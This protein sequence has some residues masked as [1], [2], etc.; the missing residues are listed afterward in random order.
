[1]EAS[2]HIIQDLTTI[3]V[4]ASIVSILFS[5]LRWPSILGYILSGLIVGPYTTSNLVIRDEASIHSI[6]ELGVI[7]LMFCIGL[8][9]DLKKL[10]QTLFPSFLA[11]FLQAIMAFFTGAMVAHCLG[12][13][14]ILGTF[15]GA[16]FAI[17]SSM[18]AVPILKHKNALKQP[19]AQ[20]TIGV[21]VLEDIFA[22]ILLVVLSN[23]RNGHF[24][25]AECI[26]LLFWITVFISSM[27]IFGRLAAQRFIKLLH[28]IANEEIAHICVVGLIL[29]LSALSSRYSNA[30][31]AFLAGAIFSST[32]INHKLETMIA[33]IRDVFTAVF[34]V[35]IGMLIDPKIIGHNIGLI[36]ILSIVVFF[37]QLISAGLGFFLSGQKGVVAFRAALPKSQ[38]GEFSFVIAALAQSLGVDN[39]YLMAITVGIALFTIIFVNL[40]SAKEEAVIDRFSRLIPK[41]LKSWGELYQNILAS[42]QTHISGNRLWNIV[43]KPILKIA[44]HFFLINAIV[45]CNAL[46][47]EFLIDHPIPRTEGYTIWLQRALSLLSLCIAL[48]FMTSLIR[49]LHLI[50]ISI[51]KHTLKG[52]F[53]KLNQHAALY[54]IFQLFIT[55]IATVFFTWLF[56][57]SSAQYLPSY[58]PILLLA[59][60]G[61]I[62]GFAFWRKLRSMNSQFEVMF[63]ES[64][65]SAL[66]SE[67]EKRN[68][69]LIKMASKKHPW[70]MQTKQIIVPKNSHLIGQTLSGSGLRQKTHTTLLGIGRNGYFS[71]NIQ[72]TSLFYPGDHLLLL[73]NESQLQAAEK[74]VSII[75]SHATLNEAEL[76]FDQIVITEQHPLLN[77]TLESAAIRKNYNLNVIGIQRKDRRMDSLQPEDII[78]AGDCLLVV[79]H[80]SAI[81][82]L[83]QLGLS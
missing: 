17:S 51:C 6:S 71:E 57:I 66:E 2:H 83:Q 10:Q 49:N 43:K 23:A 30:L 69:A 53:A 16:I 5:I 39:G 31:G 64:F 19:F 60:V 35:S 75:Q 74:F 8:E 24:N 26:N 40:L 79:G 14:P 27:L 22:V 34:F 47:C 56:L 78:K 29:W 15:L 81:Q 72:P 42:V 73:G 18:V 3:V 50:M 52:L 7:F 68:L 67:N 65:S 82:K 48:P 13:T 77:E 32:Q 41:S 55:A 46:L 4:V 54:Q 76:D 37:G 70:N 63:L 45:W 59:C 11:M 80:R 28:R 9:F 38:I 58:V 12:W 21:A 62:L 1:M 61:T 44:I 25:L 36:L 20:F 33:P